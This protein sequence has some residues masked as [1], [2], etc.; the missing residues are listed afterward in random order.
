MHCARELQCFE[1]ENRVYSD[2]VRLNNEWRYVAAI[3]GHLKRSGTR[4]LID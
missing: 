2:Y 4:Q 1:F 3:V